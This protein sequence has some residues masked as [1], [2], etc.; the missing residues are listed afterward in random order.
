MAEGEHGGK[1]GAGGGTPKRRM[2]VR[3]GRATF[4]DVEP[5]DA[6]DLAADAAAEGAAHRERDQPPPEP[7][8]RPET[9]AKR[10]GRERRQDVIDRQRRLRV[11]LA[12]SVAMV[13]VLLLQFFADVAD[14]YLLAEPPANILGTW[15]TEDPVYA[16]TSF[17][18]S[19]ELFE[20]HLGED[21]TYQFDIRSI[22]A[23]E[24]EDSWRFEITYT[25]PEEGD[26]EHVFFLY[27][28]G[29]ARVRNPS[30]VVWTRLPS[31]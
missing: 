11:L 12:L 23:I 29:T 28:D 6:L 10:I 4:E 25:S 27:A 22:R 5:E 7:G 31:G 9:P 8:P 26:L 24:T 15:V 20:L 18:I 14:P 19:D 3:W 30:H 17:V 13:A 21:G 16:A 1:G 2:V